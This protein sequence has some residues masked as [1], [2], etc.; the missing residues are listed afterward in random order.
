MNDKD[1]RFRNFFTSIGTCRNLEELTFKCQRLPA[2]RKCYTWFL[3][4]GEGSL[5]DALSALLE[6]P[7]LKRIHLGAIQ[8]S[9]QAGAPDILLRPALA[10]ALL[11]DPSAKLTE[12]ELPTCHRWCRMDGFFDKYWELVQA[13]GLQDNHPLKSLRILRFTFTSPSELSLLPKICPHLE[14][15]QNASPSSYLADRR[16]SL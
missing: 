15:I 12:L 10:E 14:L 8:C 7:M 16:L 2:H 13:K 6:L 9:V 5:H 3:M 4:A 11:I 1:Q